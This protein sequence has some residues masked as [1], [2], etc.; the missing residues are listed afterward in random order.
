MHKSVV[1]RVHAPIRASGKHRPSLNVVPDQALELHCGEA[2]AAAARSDAPAVTL[3]NNVVT[4]A[5][6]AIQAPAAGLCMPEPL[7]G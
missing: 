7:Q 5:L 3:H 2:A 4:A 6:G 1:R